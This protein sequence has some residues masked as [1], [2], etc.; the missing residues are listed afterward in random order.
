M[1]GVKEPGLQPTLAGDHVELRPLQAGDAAALLGAAADGA[2]WNMTL[3][4]VPGPDTVDAYIAAAL[5]GREAG[6]VMPFVIVR[7]ADNAVVGCTR[8]WKIDRANRKLEIGHTWLALS[9]QRTAINTEA[10]YLLLSHA[11]DAMGCIRVQ[12]Q[13]DELNV[14]SRAAIARLGAVQEGVLR[15]ERIMPDGR[16]RNTVRFSII[17]PEW[18]DVK[19]NLA[20]RLAT[21]G[22]APL[23]PDGQTL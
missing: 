5:R 20:R 9:A 7:Q 21:D 10:K 3:T 1:S 12:F 4:V 13:T 6:T 17:E 2:L 19:A 11:F 16:R 22:H 15:N 8:Y 14:R 23:V 18:P